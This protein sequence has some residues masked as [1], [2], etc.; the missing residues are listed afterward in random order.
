MAAKY[1]GKDG[2]I[3]VPTDVH[4]IYAFLFDA[5]HL[6]LSEPWSLA[7]DTNVSHIETEGVS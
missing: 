4:L 1:A 2:N 7:V 3:L 6:C 5:K